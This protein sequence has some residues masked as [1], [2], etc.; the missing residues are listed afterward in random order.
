[1]K[2][3][4]SDTNQKSKTNEGGLVIITEENIDISKW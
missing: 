2:M 3:E 4:K 1:M